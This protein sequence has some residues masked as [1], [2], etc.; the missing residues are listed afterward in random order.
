MI[1]S[2]RD[3]NCTFEEG[4]LDST[5]FT[6]DHLRRFFIDV[7]KKGAPSDDEVQQLFNFLDKKGKGYIDFKQFCDSVI[8]KDSKFFLTNKASNN[9]VEIAKEV[10][11]VSGKLSKEIE[12]SLARILE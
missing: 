9:E 10:A 5:V 3:R 2:Q 11:K 4:L 12:F 6:V 7:R 8:S 1:V